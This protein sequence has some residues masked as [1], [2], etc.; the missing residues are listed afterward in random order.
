MADP[1]TDQYYFDGLP[2]VEAT[3][4]TAG[5]LDYWLDGLPVLS[6]EASP[7][8]FGP[9]TDDFDALLISP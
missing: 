2:V 1:L 8:V 5:G 6:G 4:A 3:S 7:P 9:P